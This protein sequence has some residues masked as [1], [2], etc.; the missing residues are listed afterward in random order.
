M[1]PSAHGQPNFGHVQI[2]AKINLT[3]FC[4]AKILARC[5]YYQNFGKMPILLKF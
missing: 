3:K 5:Q 2:V 4:N 1:G